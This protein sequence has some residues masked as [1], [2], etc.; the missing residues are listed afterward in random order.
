M[1][2][3]ARGREVDPD[4]RRERLP[5]AARAPSPGRAAP[6]PHKVQ[7]GLL[8]SL[9]RAWDAWEQAHGAL[10]AGVRKVESGGLRDQKVK[11]WSPATS[12][13]QLTAGRQRHTLSAFGLEESSIHIYLIQLLA[14]D[15][16]VEERVRSA[17][18]EVFQYNATTF[19]VVDSSPHH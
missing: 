1:L 14:E 13:W 9:P 15:P 12:P 19:L 17:Y 2:P 10:D 11:G 7:G 5:Q 6:F 18:P 4:D 3:S 16:A 8:T